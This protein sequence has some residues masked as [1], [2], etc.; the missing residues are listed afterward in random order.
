VPGLVSSGSNQES[1]QDPPADEMMMI[2]AYR[3]DLYIPL[4]PEKL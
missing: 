4:S 2:S 1:D 3:A